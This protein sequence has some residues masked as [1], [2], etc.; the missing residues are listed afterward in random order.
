MIKNDKHSSVQNNTR[1]FKICSVR[2]TVLHTSRC[3]YLAF[4]DLASVDDRSAYSEVNWSVTSKFYEN[5]ITRNILTRSDY[6]GCQESTSDFIVELQTLGFGD[7]LKIIV[8]LLN[9]WTTFYITSRTIFTVFFVAAWFPGA[10]LSAV[11]L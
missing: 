5:C 9:K 3:L 4:A 7:A 10:I 2:K 6:L 1:T 11:L 8:P